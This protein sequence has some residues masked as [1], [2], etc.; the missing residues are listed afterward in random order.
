MSTYAYLVCR[1]TKQSVEAAGWGGFG[2]RTPQEPKALA[3]FCRAHVGQS[4]E[5]LTGPQIEFAELG[6][7]ELAEWSDA[8]AVE[9]YRA[10]TGEA[11]PDFD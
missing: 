10:L 2:I 4:V 9:R 1:A 7:G 5:L 8:N 3:L 11:P 6:H